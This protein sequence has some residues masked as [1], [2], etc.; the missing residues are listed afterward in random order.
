MLS[1]FWE[2]LS[3]QRKWRESSSKILANTRIHLTVQL[4]ILQWPCFFSQPVTIFSHWSYFHEY[5][6]GENKKRKNNW[7][8]HTSRQRYGDVQDVFK[9]SKIST[10][11]NISLSLHNQSVVGPSTYYLI[12][13]ILTNIRSLAMMLYNDLTQ[14]TSTMFF[15]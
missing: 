11:N 13:A 7:R 1:I 3:C 8:L 4:N 9:I 15:T 5:I 6:L 14:C 12:T 10:Q 2:N